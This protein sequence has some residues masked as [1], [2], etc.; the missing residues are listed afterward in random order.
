V[1]LLKEISKEREDLCEQFNTLR[2]QKI[3]NQFYKEEQVT[4]TM[5]KTLKD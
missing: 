2:L 1:N 5:Y 3:P 4:L